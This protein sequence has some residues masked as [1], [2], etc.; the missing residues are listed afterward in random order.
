LRKSTTIF[1]CIIAIVLF[2]FF[3]RYELCIGLRHGPL[4]R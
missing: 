1:L 4:L 3:I 2:A